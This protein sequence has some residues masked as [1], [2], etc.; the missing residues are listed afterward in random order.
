[1]IVRTTYVG[2]TRVHCKQILKPLQFSCPCRTPNLVEIPDI[3]LI[4]SVETAYP[5]QKIYLYQTPPDFFA[6]QETV[7]SYERDS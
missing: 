7:S 6:Y 5:P 1:M 3:N 2:Q 4:R